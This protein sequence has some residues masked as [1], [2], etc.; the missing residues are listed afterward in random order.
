M[1]DQIKSIIES[2]QTPIS[3]GTH[4][5]QL[6]PREVFIHDKCPE[7]DVSLYLKGE[8]EFTPICGF[9]QVPETDADSFDAFVDFLEDPES[10]M[11][12]H[13]S[14][15]LD[16]LLKFASSIGCEALNRKCEEQKIIIRANMNP[17][18]VAKSVDEELNAS[19][20]RIIV[21]LELNM[22]WCETTDVAAVNHIR[23]F[24]KLGQELRR[25]FL[26][27]FTPDTGNEEGV[28]WQFYMRCEGEYYNK[29][30]NFLGKKAP[31]GKIPVRE[32]YKASQFRNKP[33]RTI[34][35]IFINLMRDMKLR[36][37]EKKFLDIEWWYELMDECK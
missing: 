11:L 33:F 28:Q 18:I 2:E 29:C 12:P 6:I 13:N 4:T 10:A 35:E 25:L 30:L 23:L 17:V 34:P 24:F 9:I 26:F 5:K 19:T 37:Q 27:V 32:P 14:E 3:I 16:A 21:A 31:E 1:A 36:S 22:G 15:E 20:K 8:K 7:N